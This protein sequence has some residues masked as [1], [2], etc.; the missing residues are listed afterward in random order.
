MAT[1]RQALEELGFDAV[2]S[3][4]NSGNLLFTTGGRASDH[5]AAIRSKLEDVFGFELTTAE[6]KAL[7][8]LETGVRGGPE[9][10]DI[11]LEA[12]GRPIPEA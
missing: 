6:L 3:Y 7:D 11:T 5:E 1:A 12:Y 2:G 10:D 4:A 8:A 9:P